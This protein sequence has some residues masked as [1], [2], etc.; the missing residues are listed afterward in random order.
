[1]TTQKN[2]TAKGRSVAIGRDVT[3]SSIR[4]GDDVQARQGIDVKDF[5]ELLAELRKDLREAPLE[6]EVVDDL[7]AEAA[8]VQR[9][10]ERE[11]P[12]KAMILGK[13]ETITDVLA[14]AAGAGEKLVPLARTLGEMAARLF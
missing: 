10:A 13:L 12:R 8:D 3:N 4:V 1:M 5:L 2:V 14:G 11:K 9:H 7:D 6:G